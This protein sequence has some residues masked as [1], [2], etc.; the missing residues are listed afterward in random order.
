MSVTTFLEPASCVVAIAMKIFMNQI[1]CLLFTKAF[2]P[3]SGLEIRISL[4][5]KKKSCPNP[6]YKFIQMKAFFFFGKQNWW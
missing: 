6:T 1:S 2:S 3:A 5:K 4:K